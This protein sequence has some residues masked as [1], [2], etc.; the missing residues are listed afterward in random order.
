MSFSISTLLTPHL[1]DIFGA[2]DPAHRKPRIQGQTTLTA[3]ARVVDDGH[4][5][6]LGNRAQAQHTKSR[7]TL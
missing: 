3:V 1:H 4:H 2:N 7:R 5:S 6:I